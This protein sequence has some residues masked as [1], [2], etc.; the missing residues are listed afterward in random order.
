[1][2]DLVKKASE[3][4]PHQGMELS[5]SGLTFG[6][7][8][9]E[10]IR[11][12]DLKVAT[13]GVT[14]LMGPNGAG[15]SVLLRLLHGLIQPDNGHILWD[16]RSLDESVRRNQAMVFQRPVLLRRSVGANLKFVAKHCAAHQKVDI[17][18]LLQRVGL[19]D[20]ESRAARKL[21]GGE[22]Q[23]LALARALVSN[24]RVLF[25]DEP[26]ASLD[27]ASTL[28]IE[29]VVRERRD[30]GVKIFFVTHDVGQ[31]HRVADDVIFIHH[32][33]LVEQSQAKD[34]FTQP[35][36][37]QAKAYLNGEIVL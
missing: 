21:S 24:P 23:R 26:S 14:V 9:T 27:P 20:K 3:N 13:Q 7:G 32:G 17:G 35:V 25:L 31:A 6:Q 18:L 12:M 19:A 30:A 37:Q 34:F 11:S 33:K 1:M 2:L 5:V 10:I 28:I 15:K 4:N 36:S 16:G 29:N 8:K 22:Q